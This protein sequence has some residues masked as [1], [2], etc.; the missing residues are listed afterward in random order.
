MIRHFLFLKLKSSL[1]TLATFK[2]IAKALLISLLVFF[3][4]FLMSIFITDSTNKE[5]GEIAT[6]HPYEYL[7]GLIFVSVLIKRFLP[8]Y[9]PMT[10]LFPSYLPVSRFQHYC[11]CLILDFTKPFYVYFL[12]LWGT[13]AAFSHDFL[14]LLNG[15]L[16]AATSHLIGRA[17]QYPIDFRL[18]K[19]KYL[20]LGIAILNL[21]IITIFKNI[22]FSYI[23]VFVTFTLFVFLIIG[24]YLELEVVEIKHRKKKKTT[25]I[26]VPRKMLFILNNKKVKRLLIGAFA[27]KII[28]L[29]AD[30]FQFQSNHTH[31]LSKNLSYWVFGSSLML[32]TYVFNNSM[33]VWKELWLNFELRTGS[34]KDFVKMIL[35]I[36]FPF[37]L[38]DAVITIPIM[39]FMWKHPV[40]I[41]SFYLI[42]TLFF[43]CS[44]FLW[45]LLYPVNL[46]NLYNQ[47]GNSAFVGVL[48][49]IF[50]TFILTAMKFNNWFYSLIPVYIL[51]SFALMK[52]TFQLY[53]EKKY[54]VFEKLFKE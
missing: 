39:I 7:Y 13:C 48:V 21:L 15:I 42:S 36:L 19:K 46:K 41:L 32:F 47:K 25:K 27:F 1:R 26:V 29:T 20:Y 31:F 18:S 38:I 28:F 52:I 17:F 49:T 50:S 11:M 4:G 16:I 35:K 9:T 53:E 37:L 30:F 14:F 24:Y 34:Y 54:R 51:L 45:S 12:L 10:R 5:F 6:D 22:I 44:S 3:Y 2:G 23:L 40:F 33:G 8:Y 43:V